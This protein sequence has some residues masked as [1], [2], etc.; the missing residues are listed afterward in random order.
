[1]PSLGCMGG[2]YFVIR[3]IWDIIKAICLHKPK[4]KNHLSGNLVMSSGPASVTILQQS[5]RISICDHVYII[6][7]H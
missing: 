7:I 3:V 4:K 2:C 6:Y 5:C 1:M